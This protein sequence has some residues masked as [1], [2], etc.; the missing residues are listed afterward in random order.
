MG[1][2]AMNNDQFEALYPLTGAVRSLFHGLGASVTA[3]HAGSGV[4]SGMRGVLESLISDGPQ[5]VPQLARARPVS[6]QHI[7]ALVNDL[8]AGGYVKLADNP[9]HR[10]SK[11]V[12]PS[13][14]G[15]ACLTALR[16]REAEAFKHLDLDIP[17]DQLE[18]ATQV[19]E[20]LNEG[21]RGTAW[22]SIRADLPALKK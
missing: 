22:W 5:S 10:R 13:Q 15:R 6:R 18:A 2:T 19:L 20:K 12:Q 21:V 17:T 9:A 3:L 4:S 11:L 1:I 16:A 7:Q 14:S 8:L